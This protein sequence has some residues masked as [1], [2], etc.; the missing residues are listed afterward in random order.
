MC[1]YICSCVRCISLPFICPL[2]CQS[3]HADVAVTLYCVLKM[4]RIPGMAA[5]G[6]CEVK[7]MKSTA[8]LTHTHT[9][10]AF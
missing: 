9:V 10:T 2:V 3:E 8:V 5:G 4:N 7:Q 1:I 6:G